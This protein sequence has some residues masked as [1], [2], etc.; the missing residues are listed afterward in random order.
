MAK[1]VIPGLG[2]EQRC[3]TPSP[4]DKP[5]DV[6]VHLRSGIRPQE[7]DERTV[8]PLGS[9]RE[10]IERRELLEEFALLRR[11]EIPAPDFVCVLRAA[12]VH[13][14]RSL[15]CQRILEREMNLVWAARDLSDGS[16]R[17][18]EHHGVAGSDAEVSKP[19][20][21]LPSRMH[22]LGRGR[23]ARVIKKDVVPPLEILYVHL[24]P[25]LAGPKSRTRPP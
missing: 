13:D 24:H 20:C 6:I 9:R 21:Q 10:R 11:C 17:R 15:R 16:Y 19:V 22:G 18:M 8:L 2:L 1:R 3:G 12:G 14:Q 25:L 23:L 4:H 5:G 7:L